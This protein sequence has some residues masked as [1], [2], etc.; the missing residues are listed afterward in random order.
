MSRT[1]AEVWVCPV[2][3]QGEDSASQ[4]AAGIRLINQLGGF[5]VLIVGRGGGSLEDLWAFN[6]EPVAHAIYQSRIPVVSGIGHETD[7][8]IA[9]LVADCRALTP[10]DAATK[11]T[12]NATELWQGLLHSESRLRNA[13]VGQLEAARRRLNELTTRRAFRRP[14]ERVHDL[15][16]RLD[17]WNE[18]LKRAVRQ[19]MTV[20]EQRLKGDAAR[21]ESLS[22][23]NVLSRGYSLTRKEVDRAVLRSTEQVQPGERLITTLLRGEVLSRVEE[24]RPAT[25]ESPMDGPAARDAHDRRIPPR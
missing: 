19:R 6:E 5:D 16:Q 1:A 20:A 13:L 11:A 21:L 15:D 8:T 12:P 4:I 23:L 25:S 18:R 9:D 7:L 3:V 24:V 17:D 2:K 10:T 14:L 22:P